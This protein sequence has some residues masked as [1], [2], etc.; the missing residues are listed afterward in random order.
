M[1]SGV[2]EKPEICFNSGLFS[3]EKKGNGLSAT[4]IFFIILALTI[5]NVGVFILCKRYI[6]RKI[7]ERVNSEEIDSRIS[8]VVSSYLQLKDSR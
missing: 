8:N 4:A 7:V 2:K 5:F 3:A 6:Q 1:C